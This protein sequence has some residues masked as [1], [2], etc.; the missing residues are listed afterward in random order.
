LTG[1][2]LNQIVFDGSGFSHAKLIAVGG[3]AELVPT[4][5]EPTGIL[6]FGDIN[7]DGSINNSDI[8]A[9]LKALTNLNAYKTL[10][11]FNDSQ[12]ITVADTNYDDVVTNSDI[13]SLINLVGGGAGS[14]AAV[15]EP[16]SLALLALG[17]VLVGQRVRRNR[18]KA[19]HTK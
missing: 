19:S 15:P 18:K 2:Q 9:F 5:T 4:N 8:A 14:L 17:G 13:Q 10:R 6:K 1:N 12:L 3:G 11:G 7:Q 16:S